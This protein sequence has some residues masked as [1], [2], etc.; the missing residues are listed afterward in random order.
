MRA[1]V[2][3]LAALVAV[4]LGCRPGATG[5][6]V[7]V[8]SELPPEAAAATFELRVSGAPGEEPLTAPFGAFGAGTVKR[9]A[10]VPD[11]DVDRA[12]LLELV[13]LDARERPIVSRKARTRFW[14]SHVVLLPLELTP[15]CIETDAVT[16]RCRPEETCLRGRC[17]PIPEIRPETLA[18]FVPAPPVP[19]AGRAP[20]DAGARADAGGVEAGAVDAPVTS[21]APPLVDAR[22]QGGPAPPGLDG[23]AVTLPADAG[24]PPPEAGPDGGPRVL[25][26]APGEEPPDGL[27]CPG[28]SSHLPCAEDVCVLRGGTATL[29]EYRCDARLQCKPAALRACGAAC[30]ATC[31]R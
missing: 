30:D 11:G 13:A 8:S 25:T 4:G 5:L 12:F 7:E 18:P 16:R 21:D 9:V 2:P 24:P 29:Y 6:V 26:L 1:P 27:L 14:R 31:R 23:D 19:D 22:P 10:L 15:D 17:A 20:L 28:R 3:L